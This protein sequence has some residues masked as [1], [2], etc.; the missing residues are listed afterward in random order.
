MCTSEKETKDRQIHSKSVSQLNRIQWKRTEINDYRFVDLSVKRVAFEKPQNLL[1]NMCAPPPHTTPHHIAS[2]HWNLVVFSVLHFDIDSNR[3]VYLCNVHCCHLIIFFELI[4][5]TSI[6]LTI[7]TVFF[8]AFCVFTP[9]RNLLYSIRGLTLFLSYIHVVSFFFVW[10]CNFMYNH[11]PVSCTCSNRK[12]QKK[13][14]N[15]NRSDKQ[16]RI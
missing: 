10:C 3:S 9:L 14:S 11:C 2:H 15:K 6:S 4:E 16:K 7:E 5:L 1:K 8:L 13:A 12:E